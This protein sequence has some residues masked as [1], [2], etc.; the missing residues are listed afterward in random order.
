MQRKATIAGIAVGDACPLA[1]IGGPCVIESEEMA[2]DVASAMRWTCE[3][4]R[5]PYIF[6]ASF[7][8]ANRTRGT[9]FRG[10]G[11]AEGIRILADLRKT[12]HVPVLTDIHAPEQA[13]RVAEHVDVL[14]IPAF[15]CRQTDLIIAAGRTGR[16]LNIKK[17]QFVAPRDMGYA[18][19]KAFAAGAPAVILTE[20]GTTFGYHDLVVDF[21]SL[22]EMA[23]IGV[24]VCFDATHSVQRPG[25]AAGQSGG[26]RRH[27]E[28]LSRAAVAA[29]ADLV[30]AEVHPD[31]SRAFSDAETQLPLAEVPAWL[32]SLTAIARA[33]GRGRDHSLTNS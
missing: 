21:R 33:I 18:V 24:P 26:D 13:E 20:R 10:P 7:D 5:V 6:K 14:Q 12:A 31:P 9:S 28:A 30:F 1:F 3:L 4:L 22:R 27:I 2:L 23:D 25:A 29:G 17:G 8:K 11:L 15:L 16:P 32:A 19:E